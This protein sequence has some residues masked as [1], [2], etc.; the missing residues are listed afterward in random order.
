MAL[1][2]Y[3]RHRRDC[4]AGHPEDSKSSDLDERKKGWAAAN[5]RYL[6]PV[7]WPKRSV[8]KAPENVIG[9]RQKPLQL[10]GRRPADGTPRHRELTQVGVD[11][12]PAADRVSIADATSAFIAN[13]EN[14]G[15]VLVTVNKYRTLVRQLVAYGESRGYV[16]VDQLTI[17]DMDRFY[18]SWK[19]G[20]RARAK[21]LEH[22]KRSSGFAGSASGF[23]MT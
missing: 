19:D 13:F 12:L 17:T 5:V 9:T 2:L 4:R 15:I 20:K 16:M 6:F 7:R 8:G 14:R 10:A 21:K 18:A 11:L 3:R 1:N 22:L 23:W